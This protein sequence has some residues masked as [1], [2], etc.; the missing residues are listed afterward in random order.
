MY[1]FYT[2]AKPDILFAITH[3]IVVLVVGVYL[4]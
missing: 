3:K 1:V 2:W 4:I